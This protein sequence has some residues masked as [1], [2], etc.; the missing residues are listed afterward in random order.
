MRKSKNGITADLLRAFATLFVFL[1]HAKGSIPKSEAFP[2]VF[3]WLTC[4]PAWAGVWIFLFLSG[5]GIGYG[6]FTEKYELFREGKRSARK[7]FG[8]YA[9]RFLK[10]AP[11]YYLYCF[12]YEVLSGKLL[13]WQNPQYLLKILTFTFNAH[14]SVEGLGHLWY[15]SLAMQLYLFMPFLYLALRALKPERNKGLFIA[16]FGTVLVL[17][18]LARCL[19]VNAGLDWYTW[20]YTNCLVN[21]DLVILGMLVA[22]MK[23]HYSAPARGKA[24]AKAFAAVLFAGM[25]LYNC[26]IY[27]RSSLHDLFVYRCL[28]PSAYA[29]VCSLLLFLSGSEEARPVRWYKAAIKWFAG[30]SYAFYILHLA[31]FAYLNATLAA[32]ARFAELSPVAQYFAYVPLAFLLTLLLAVP[33]QLFGK[34][35]ITLYRHR[36][37]KVPL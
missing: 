20:S 23:L 36:E 28:L 26:F 5:F 37:R 16:V 6:F 7:F 3:R 17:G 12:L 2:A 9:M 13:F 24:W 10:I 34:A 30:N 35:V 29:A 22:D 11:L 4:L 1:L 33:F 27:E 25:V 18:A 8:F 15:I 19:I 21:L 32:T 31:T 14:A